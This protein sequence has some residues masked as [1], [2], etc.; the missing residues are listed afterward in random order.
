MCVMSAGPLLSSHM[1]HI[2]V[3]VDGGASKTLVI[4]AEGSVTEIATVTGPAS[5]VRPGEADQSA[6]VITRLI[7]EALAAC[8]KEGA[9]PSALCVGVAGV[10]GGAAYS[11]LEAG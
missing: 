2:V 5:A 8:G 1:T 10:G 11:A 3:G 7:G 9:M 4:V 6:D